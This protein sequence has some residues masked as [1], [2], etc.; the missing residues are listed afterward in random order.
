MRRRYVW[1]RR[2]GAGAREPHSGR[3]TKS[4]EAPCSPTKAIE[5]FHLTALINRVESAARAAGAGRAVLPAADDPLPRS[6][7]AILAGA[8]LAASLL[9]GAAGVRAGRARARPALVVAS[10]QAARCQTCP[11]PRR[12]PFPSS[13]PRLAL[14]AVVRELSAGRP[15]RSARPLSRNVQGSPSSRRRRVPSDARA[16]P[17][18]DC[19]AAADGPAPR[20]RPSG[21]CSDA[22]N[23]FFHLASFFWMKNFTRENCAL[24]F[25]SDIVC[26][27]TRRMTKP[28][29]EERETEIE[30]KKA[31]E[32]EKREREERERR[33][34]EKRE[35]R[36]RNREKERKREIEIERK[37]SREREKRERQIEREKREERER[38]LYGCDKDIYVVFQRQNVYGDFDD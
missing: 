34:R 7:G 2:A 23:F 18:A 35:E 38:C 11:A 27:E 36:D 10:F 16:A 5:D 3:R 31:R 9:L 13:P 25:P 12:T 22:A 32:R 19:R 8:A 28:T 26:E 4:R 20:L 15:R 14:L 37:K 1:E 21:K 30:R 6:A 17:P 29:R 24:V 33:E